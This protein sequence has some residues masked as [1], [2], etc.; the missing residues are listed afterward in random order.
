MNWRIDKIWLGKETQY[1]KYVITNSINIKEVSEKFCDLALQAY[2]F[3]G[4]GSNR[5]GY[6]AVWFILS[7][8]Y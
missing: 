1:E 6:R 2:F 4:P 5:K 7:N 3:E 8:R